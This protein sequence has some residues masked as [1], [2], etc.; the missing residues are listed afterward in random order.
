MAS[1]EGGVF[2]PETIPDTSLDIHPALAYF[3][4]RRGKGRCAMRTHVVQP[5]CK[6]SSLADR[7]GRIPALLHA[8][9][10]LLLLLPVGCAYE[11]VHISA[12]GR[13]HAAISKM[14][15]AALLSDNPRR[16]FQTILPEVRSFSAVD[17]AWTDG[18]TFFVRYRE[19]GIVSWTAPP[20][21]KQ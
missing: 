1:R 16:D 5:M 8:F 2:Q 11:G 17:S 10:I 15:D 19:G 14:L 6:S 4:S 12:I 9:E 3:H 20:E 7:L 13:D 18:T 21:V